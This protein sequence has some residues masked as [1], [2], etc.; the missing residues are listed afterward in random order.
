MDRVSRT[1]L[2]L[3][4]Q[5]TRF[6]LWI[7]SMP[8]AISRIV[9]Y[10]ATMFGGAVTSRF[11][12]NH[13]RS[14]A[15]MRVPRSQYSCRIHITLDN[16]VLVSPPFTRVCSSDVWLEANN[17]A[18][19]LGCRRDMPS[20]P[21]ASDLSI[22]FWVTDSTT[23]T[24]TLFRFHLPRYTFP[25]PPEPSMEPILRVDSSSGMGKSPYV[26]RDPPASQCGQ[27]VISEWL[28]LVVVLILEPPDPVLDP[29]MSLDLEGPLQDPE[30]LVS[31]LLLVG[32][33]LV[34][35]TVSH[36]ELPSSEVLVMRRSAAAAGKDAVELSSL[37]GGAMITK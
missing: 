5:C 1:F 2:P 15:S 20:A 29:T 3:R 4:S 19:M 30:L 7:K 8:C 22:L 9:W 6:L 33:L 35:V 37:G 31:C 32:L 28:L 23:L 24:A 17:V 11:S 21:S 18:T 16:S 13:P 27:Q 12:L 14:T 10:M 26:K 25:N 36:V 34:S